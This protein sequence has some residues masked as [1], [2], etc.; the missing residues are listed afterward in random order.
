M[1]RNASS[2]VTG[3]RSMIVLPTPRPVRV[4]VPRS[5][6]T[7]W[8]SQSTYWTGTGSFRPYFSR[9]A[10]SARWLWSSPASASAGSPGSARTPANTTMLETRRTIS[11]A[12]A[13]RSRYP[14]MS[15]PAASHARE[16]QSRQ[17]I[18]PHLDAGHVTARP[19]EQVVVVEVDDVAVVQQRGDH[20]LVD[21]AALGRIG[22]RAPVRKRLVDRGVRLAAVVQRAL[23]LLLVE[24]V[25]V[26]V[27]APRP[28]HLEGVEVAL[29]AP[30]E[31]GRELARL[32]L[33]REAGLACHRL[34]D[35]REA[36][37]LRGGL[38]EQRHRDRRL[39]AALLHELPGPG[40][41]PPRAA[42]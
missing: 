2:S 4:D 3:S 11:E 22:C 20:A 26:G 23:A 21:R 27:D 15:D 1:L 36:L 37:L 13:R 6:R 28:A 30:V 9:I 8:P 38:H 7:T 12:P 39:H 25:A 24:Q 16:A 10:V 29:V 31:R 40:E 5:P 41:V 19:G 35:L 33:D 18:G 42:Q 17:P 14:C 32:D 34:D